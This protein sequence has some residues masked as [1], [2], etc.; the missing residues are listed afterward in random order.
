MSTDIALDSSGDNLS[1]QNQNHLS[2]R[3]R[4]KAPI[5]LEPGLCEII[6]S[7]Q[8]ANRTNRKL[9]R[10][11]MAPIRVEECLR[12]NEGPPYLHYCTVRSDIFLVAYEEITY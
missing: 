11:R 6:L 2:L 9:R 10:T 7:N 12:R 1:T 8:W 3:I 4:T 5:P